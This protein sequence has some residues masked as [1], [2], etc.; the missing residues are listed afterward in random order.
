MESK[1]KYYPLYWVALC[2]LVVAGDYATGPLIQFPIASVVPIM[3]ASWYSGR[4]WGIGLAVFLA[5]IRFVLALVWGE[6]L[7]LLVAGI[8]FAIRSAVFIGIALLVSHNAAL[9]RQIKTLH[10]LLPICMHCKKIRTTDGSW[11]QIEAY[12]SEQTEA[13][14]SHGLCD[15]CAVK[16]YPEYTKK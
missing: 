5:S 10:G 8:N 14:F 7:S 9:T 3:L 11:R 2:A 6:P 12:I 1:Q 4:A 13:E 15:E 16:L